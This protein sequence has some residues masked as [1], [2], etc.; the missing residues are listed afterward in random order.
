MEEFRKIKDFDNYEISNFG[1]VK[2]SITEKY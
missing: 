1:N 2:N